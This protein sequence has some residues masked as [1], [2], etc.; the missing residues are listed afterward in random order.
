MPS[1]KK[2]KSS[3]RPNNNKQISQVAA[4]REGQDAFK[5]VVSKTDF[6]RMVRWPN[7]GIEQENKGHSRQHHEVTRS[8]ADQRALIALFDGCWFF[9]KSLADL[10]ADGKF[11]AKSLPYLMQQKAAEE[12]ADT[13]AAKTHLIHQYQIGNRELRELLA[14]MDCKSAIHKSARDH[15]RFPGIEAILYPLFHKKLATDENIELLFGNKNWV[16]FAVLDI[17]SEFADPPPFN[18]PAGARRAQFLKPGKVKAA[19]PECANCGKQKGD[20]SRCVACHTVHYC[21]SDCQRADWTLHRPDCFEK[22]GKEVTD[23]VLEKAKTEYQRRQAL[24]AAALEHATTILDKEKEACWKAMIAE[25]PALVNITSYDC[26]VKKLPLDLP[27]FAPFVLAKVAARLELEYEMELNLGMFP[28]GIDFDFNQYSGRG[29]LIRNPSTNAK[30]I[31]LLESLFANGGEGELNG[32]FLAGMFVVNRIDSNTHKATWQIVP[33][34]S[35]NAD[36]NRLDRFQLYLQAAKGL[37]M[38]VPE[39]VDLG[40]HNPGMPN[41]KITSTPFG[42]Y[43]SI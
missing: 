36:H 22:Q 10:D 25:S 7:D 35:Y 27:P 20:M 19:H 30:I 13:E 29:G 18:T 8:N 15:R 32:H 9:G 39:D 28:E 23:S 33:T 3:N 2:K 31:V 40:I 41:M 17:G 5:Y 42:D 34:P 12:M 16:L 38:A 6:R 37:A 1:S 4:Q 21:S 24:E 11:F 43:L 26:Y 14:S